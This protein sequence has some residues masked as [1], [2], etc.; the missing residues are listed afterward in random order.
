M[1]LPQILKDSTHALNLP[2][3]FAPLAALPGS[4]K[5]LPFTMETQKREEWC[6]AAVSVSVARF[7]EQ[8]SLWR[9]CSL[10]NEELG[11]GNCC[12]NPIPAECNQP[13][14]LERGLER[15]LHLADHVQT[16]LSFDSVADEIDAER[17]V[18]CWIRWP[19]GTGH[20]VVLNGYSRDFASAPTKEYVSV[21]D[22]KYPSADYLF[23]K[24][25]NSYRTHG[26]WRFSYL[27]HA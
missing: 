23:S 10:V 6:W 17:P 25:Q 24:F 15:V 26:T 22:S 1:P 12:Q 8:G 16:P 14:Y 27:T 3:A 18:G 19:D 9:Q 13:W 21:R 7:Y 20:F 4:G 11:G 5:L 2:G